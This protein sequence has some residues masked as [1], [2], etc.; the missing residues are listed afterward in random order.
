MCHADDLSYLFSNGLEHKAPD[1]QSDEFKVMQTMV[2]LW[3]SFAIHGNPNNPQS[4]YLKGI[5][6]DPLPD[7]RLIYKVLNIKE[8]LAVIEAPEAKRMA[9]WDTMYDSDQLY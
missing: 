8:Q 7:N 2:E 4:P 5:Q 6:W 1:A 3:T 9:F